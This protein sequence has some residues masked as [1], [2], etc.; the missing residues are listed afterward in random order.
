MTPTA[1]QP[2]KP[3]PQPTKTTTPLPTNRNNHH[4]KNLHHHH[5]QPQPTTIGHHINRQPTAPEN[6]Q[7]NDPPPNGLTL[8]VTRSTNGEAKPEKLASRSESCDA[9]RV[10]ITSE[11]R[12]RTA[13]RPPSREKSPRIELPGDRDLPVLVLPAA[14]VA[15]GE[16]NR[17]LVRRDSDL[18]VYDR[19]EALDSKV[20]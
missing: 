19:L 9:S 7:Q 5:E 8:D 17:E 4:H 15:Y 2:P 16:V 3:T 10:S 1:S 6:P 18:P 14:F 20:G 13:P 11:P 12:G